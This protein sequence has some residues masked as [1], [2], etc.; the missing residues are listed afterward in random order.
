MRVSKAFN[1]VH[2]VTD[3]T[4]SVEQRILSSIIGQMAPVKTTLQLDQR[5]Q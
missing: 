3:A 1:G 5:R 2:A 4:M